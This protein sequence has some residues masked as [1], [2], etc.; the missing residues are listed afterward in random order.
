MKEIILYLT[1]KYKGNIK[2]IYNALINKESIDQNKLSEILLELENKNINYI[3][4]FDEN[5]PQE[6]KSIKH[7]PYVLFYRGNLELLNSKKICL[8]ADIDSNNCKLN[9]NRNIKKIVNKHTLITTNFKNLD[10]FIIQEWRKQKGNVI[11]PLASG[12]DYDSDLIL[13]DNELII[14]MYPP[15]TNPKL[16]RFKERNVLIALLA[17]YLISFSAKNNSGIINLALCFANIGKEVYCFPGE[18]VNDG[19]TFLIKSGANLITALADIY[20]YS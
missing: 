20:Y 14:S 3:T 12:I 10:T 18:N 9:I 8:T 16:I 6:L 11:F 2:D 5:Y 17:D 7:S 15:G 4:V 13:N 1:Y 19:N